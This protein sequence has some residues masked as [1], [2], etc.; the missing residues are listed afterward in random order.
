MCPYSPNNQ[1]KSYDLE[2]DANSV[3]ITMETDDELF[4][5]LHAVCTPDE[6]NV[7]SLGS[8]TN[9][10]QQFVI[11]DSFANPGAQYNCSVLKFTI[12]RSQQ[13]FT[14]GDSFVS[15]IFCTGS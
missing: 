13:V 8:D 1:I 3:N 9:E 14:S 12:S 7:V 10:T 6:C 5:I 11:L 15:A 2:N 4:K